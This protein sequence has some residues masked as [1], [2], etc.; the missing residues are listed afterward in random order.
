MRLHAAHAGATL[1]DEPSFEVFFLSR[2][3]F[4]KKTG[5]EARREVRKKNNCRDCLLQHFFFFFCSIHTRQ[6]PRRCAMNGDHAFSAVTTTRDSSRLTPF[7]SSFKPGRFFLLLL[8]FLFFFFF[9]LFCFCSHFKSFQTH[10]TPFISSPPLSLRRE[11]ILC[12]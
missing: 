11:K 4:K 1:E 12:A 6:K 5:K 9:S 8:L 2:F 10:S 3:L 7:V